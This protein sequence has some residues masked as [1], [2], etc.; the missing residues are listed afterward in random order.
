M[1]NEVLSLSEAQSIATFTSNQFSLFTFE[2]KILVQLADLRLLVKLR[3][4][5]ASK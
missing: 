1:N 2:Q 5:V 3:H 4:P